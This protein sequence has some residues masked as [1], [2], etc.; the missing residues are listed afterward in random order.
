MPRRSDS[1]S[2]LRENSIPRADSDSTP[3]LSD[4]DSASRANSIPRADS[5]PQADLDSTPQRSDWDSVPRVAVL[6]N[7]K[8]TLANMIFGRDLERSPTGSGWKRNQ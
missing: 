7:W 5:I 3:Q 2:A 8:E 6:E 4:L 1:D